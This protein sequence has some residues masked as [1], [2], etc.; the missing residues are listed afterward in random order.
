M[1]VL[2]GASEVSNAYSAVAARRIEIVERWD[3]LATLTE[4]WEELAANCGV[5][6][7]SSYYWVN[8]WRVSYGEKIEPRAIACWRDGILVGLLPLGLMRRPL[9]NRLS[10]VPVTSL[11]LFANDKTPFNQLLV[12]PAYLDVLDEMLGAAVNGVPQWTVLTL[13][14]LRWDAVT[15][16]AVQAGV[17][18]GLPIRQRS[19]PQS[20]VV[21]LSHGYDA[22][23]GRCSRNFRHAIRQARR[24]VEAKAHRMHVD[25]D[26]RSRLLQRALEVGSRSW[27]GY[28]GTSL[29]ASTEGRSFLTRLHKAFGPRGEMWLLVLEIDGHD[30]GSLVALRR[31]STAYAYVMDFDEA[32]ALLS[33]GRY[34]IDRLLEVSGAAGAARVDMLRRTP[35]TARFSDET[36]PL[37]QVQLYRRTG[38]AYAVHLAEQRLQP[39]AEPAWNA[40]RGARPSR[41]TVTDASTDV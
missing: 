16:A 22:Y 32:Y 31:G 1:G 2:A 35:F 14:N 3:E 7:F 37:V 23:L 36:Y 15:A 17:E 26:G 24:R 9:S 30:V 10:W 29:A 27:K 13:E 20:T 40:I 39:L 28:V 38:L 41:A 6:P 5:A 8:G 34:L 21:D 12:A 33:P 18:L 4:A 25:M 19:G 11:Q